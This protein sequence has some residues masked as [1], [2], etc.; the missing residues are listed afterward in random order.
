MRVVS[1]G[2]VANRDERGR[3]KKRRFETKAKARKKLKGPQIGQSPVKSIYFCRQCRAWHL[4][5]RR[6][7]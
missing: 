5:C 1:G 4:S 3:C 2:K 6:P 7:F